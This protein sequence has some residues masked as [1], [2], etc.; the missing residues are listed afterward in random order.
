MSALGLYLPAR[1]LFFF[2]IHTAA[3]RKSQFSR[4]SLQ[5]LLRSSDVLPYSSAHNILP[6]AAA[7]LHS[8]CGFYT[9]CC[10]L[11]P[12]GALAGLLSQLCHPPRLSSRPGKQ[13]PVPEESTQLRTLQMTSAPFFQ[14]KGGNQELGWFLPTTHCCARKGRGTGKQSCHKIPYRF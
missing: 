12:S 6:R 2:P 3:F 1:P 13:K 14:H 11:L 10:L 5:L 9:S 4:V 8:P 7:G